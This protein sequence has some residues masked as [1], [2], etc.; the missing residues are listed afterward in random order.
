MQS[1]ALHLPAEKTGPYRE[2]GAY[3]SQH[4]Q[5]LALQEVF[6]ERGL[7][8]QGYGGGGGVAEAV[9]VDNHPFLGQTQTLGGRKNDALV[10]LVRDKAAQVAGSDVIRVQQLG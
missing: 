8:G 3:R 4:H 7:H 9:D 10:R 1:W 5:A 6:V 2:A